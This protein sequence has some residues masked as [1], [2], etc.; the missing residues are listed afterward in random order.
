MDIGYWILYIKYEHWVVD[1]GYWTVDIG[2][3]F[4]IG[5]LLYTLDT[6]VERWTPDI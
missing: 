2:Q 6:E 1:S 5:Y 4:K 3:I